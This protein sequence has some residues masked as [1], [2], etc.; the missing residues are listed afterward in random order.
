MVHP[1]KKINSG[2]EDLATMAGGSGALTE[3]IVISILL[4]LPIASCI[5]RFRCVS[6]SWRKLLSDPDLIRKILFFQTSDDRNNLKIL[7]TGKE[8][9]GSADRSSIYSYETLRPIAGHG[10]DLP[11]PDG[12]GV[13]QLIGCCGGIFCI[14][15]LKHSRVGYD[16]NDIV[17]WNP[18]TSETKFLP[19][20]P[21]H[22]ARTPYTRP[23][24]IHYGAEY[25]GFG[26]DPETNDYKVLRV[27]HFERAYTDDDEECDPREIYHGDFP[28]VFTEV[29]SLKNDSWKTLDVSND[30]VVSEYEGVK[31]IHQQWNLHQSCE[32]SRND[33]C[34][35]FQSTSEVCD[36]VSFDMSTEVFEHTLVSPP[37]SLDDR[38][39]FTMSCFMVKGTIMVTFYNETHDETWGMLKYGVAESW[40]KLFTISSEND[41][42]LISHLEVWKDGTYICCCEERFSHCA[43]I[44][45]FICDLATGK[46]IHEFDE[47]EDRDY[48][49]KAR[50]FTPTQVS[51]S[52]L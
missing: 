26:F 51:L 17:L 1:K 28:L 33:K 11:K 35:W 31:Y 48:S 42:L 29:Y 22:P 2:R 38:C 19:P 21:H 49:F 10:D 52:L 16:S 6:R 30:E 41:N 50:I 45:I 12:D 9:T 39:D 40:T 43:P 47:N 24:L 15:Y 18:L 46:N 32:A 34:Y 7:I 25:F 4:R 27:S 14:S 3:D 5:A 13:L 44:K 8:G 23:L 37:Q 36:L 20:G